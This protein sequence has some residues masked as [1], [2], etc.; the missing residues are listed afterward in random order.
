MTSHAK[1]CWNGYHS[2]PLA[3]ESRDAT[4]FITGDDT[5]TSERHKDIMLQAMCTRNVLMKLPKNSQMSLDAL[6]TVCCGMKTL[7]VHFGELATT[8]N[9][10]QTME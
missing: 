10:V 2:L 9:T 4:T 6:M 1:D 7:R 3:P 5:N 8:S